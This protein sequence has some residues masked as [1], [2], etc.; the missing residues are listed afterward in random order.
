MTIKTMSLE[1][2]KRER[3]KLEWIGTL[4]CQFLNHQEEVQIKISEIT[5]TGARLE[6]ESLRVGP[7]NIVVQSSLINFILNI[8]LPTGTVSTP[9]R[10]IGWTS[11]NGRKPH[12]N[13]GVLFLKKVAEVPAISQSMKK[14]GAKSPM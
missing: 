2:R 14:E 4:E 5:E 13:L 6:M 8:N 9:I 7:F 11:Q 10:I 1:R 12:L 3:S